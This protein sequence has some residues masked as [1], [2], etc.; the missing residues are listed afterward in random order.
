MQTFASSDGY[1]QVGLVVAA[2][3]QTWQAQHRRNLLVCEA[4][5]EVGGFVEQCTQILSA[6]S[7]GRPGDAVRG[8]NWLSGQ[9]QRVRLRL[10]GLVTEPVTR[11]HTSSLPL[12]A[13]RTEINWIED[14]SVELDGCLRRG[15]SDPSGAEFGEALRKATQ[16]CERLHLVASAV[17]PDGSGRIRTKWNSKFGSAAG[18]GG[19]RWRSPGLTPAVV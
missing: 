3:T 6:C 15:V 16:L 4:R 19:S 13:L 5:S 17:S 7:S 8:L 1:A 2:A 9:G 14:L 10:Q 12:R 11:A 18:R